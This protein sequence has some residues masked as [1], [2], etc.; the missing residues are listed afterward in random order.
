MNYSIRIKQLAL[1]SLLLGALHLYPSETPSITNT[2]EKTEQVSVNLEP[3]IKKMRTQLELLDL[4]LENIALDIN[5]KVI[6]VDKPQDLLKDLRA[7]RQQVF[8]YKN[9]EFLGA[10]PAYVAS[11]VAITQDLATHIKQIVDNKFAAIPTFD[12]TKRSV[13]VDDEIP[14]E[15]LDKQL[16]ENQAIIQS[17]LAKAESTGLSWYN[18]VYRALDNHLIQPAKKNNVA[19][20]TGIT[21]LA[22]LAGIY[23]W[24]HSDSQNE[25]LR[26]VLGWPA[27]LDA[28]GNL[29]EIWH[30]G[31]DLVKEGGELVSKEGTPRPLGLLGRAENFVYKNT[32]G[33]MPVG[34][35]VLVPTLTAASWAAANKISKFFFRQRDTLINKLKGGQYKF[36]QTGIDK[37]DGNVTFEDVIGCEHAKKE[38]YSLINSLKNI[39]NLA[40]KKIGPEQG[41]L[42]V[43]EPGTGKT[44]F[45]KG[46]CG[47]LKKELAG[48]KQAAFKF[49]NIPISII[50]QPEHAGGFGGIA[51]LFAWASYQAPCVIFID[52]IDLLQAQRTGNTDLLGEFLSAMS[53]F[54][55]NDP[56]KPVVIIAATN[57]PENLDIAL[58][59]KGRFGTTLYFDYPTLN[60]RKEYLT[61]RLGTITNL[62]N[63]NIDQLALETYHCT[64]E[65]LNSIVKEAFRKAKELNM[66]L[67]QRLLEVSFDE[68]IRGILPLDEK[69]LSSKEMSIIACHQAG[70]A[71]AYTLLDNESQVGKVT[72]APISLK[73]KEEHVW[74]QYWNKEDNKQK[75]I[76]HG[77]VFT[78]KE[79]DSLNLDTKEEKLLH[80]RIIQAGNLAQQILLGTSSTNYHAEDKKIALEIAKSVV[81]DGLK[82]D[83]LP[84]DIM[85][86]KMSQAYELMLKCEKEM[87]E[88]LLKKKD[89]LNAIASVLLEA[90]S[91]SGEELQQIMLMVEMKNM[92][93]EEQAALLAKLQKEAGI[94]ADA[95]SK[96]ASA[97]NQQPAA[98]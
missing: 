94:E 42:L 34:Q 91:L 59:R 53:G 38:A 76:A 2:P 15:Q 77:K 36:G 96:P 75:H 72:M 4:V 39:K 98:A 87:K 46:F 84:K 74:A 83:Q 50:T 70:T 85:T 1:G 58:R 49:Y 3:I 5:N 81:F 37:W 97:N 68:Q 33:F 73:A 30:N 17:T 86:Q 52:E 16:N 47:E 14:A 19:T 48:Q 82:P 93:P 56:E 41:I 24:Y 6:K 78:Y 62:D 8:Q 55:N 7:L 27:H 63:L 12:G 9:D 89:Y 29:N 88:I 57:K 31:I 95:E 92:S 90:K 20:I 35:F 13:G 69:D 26:K 64:Y 65:D 67:N 66:A 11:R 43:G 22:G 45:A 54:T 79:H 10:A 51:N 60:N 21:A 44:E 40:R 18:K 23:Y 80:C 25:M 28:A 32:H 61:N 71:L